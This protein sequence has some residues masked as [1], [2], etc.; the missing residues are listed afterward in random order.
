MGDAA[1]AP[2]AQTLTIDLGKVL[3]IDPR[4]QPGGAPFG[5]PPSN[6]FVASAGAHQE[7]Y[8][9]GL[10]NPF[11][12]S[13]APDGDLIVADVGETTWEEVDVGRATG[14]PAATTLA[15]AN[16]GWPICEGECPS[17]QAG[18]TDPF[19]QYGHG[20]PAATTGC[21]IIGGYVVRH[22]AL[23]GLTGRYLYGDH[24]RPDLRTLDLNVPGGDPRP[25][26]VSIPDKGGELLGFGEDG[27]GCVY[28][29]TDV[30]AYRVAESPTA[31]TACP[32]PETASPDSTPPK[33]RLGGR[34]QQLHRFLQV[35]A[36]CNEAC[37]L[38]ASGSLH[39]PGA[40]ASASA[41]LIG[42]SRSGKPGERTPLRLKLRRTAF[43]RARL[44]LKRG[45]K[46]TARVAVTATDPS[47]NR[48][49]KTLRVKLL[50]PPSRGGGK[51]GSAMLS[52]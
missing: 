51:R 21:A 1:N 9:L 14:T 49:R 32:V 12:A 17:P 11:R 8:A 28:A 41:G 4:E 36:T 2:N 20:V 16:L 6:P 44:A 35:F 42:V 30:T 26:G 25:A 52:P 39:L 10:R 3:R 50:P 13:F 38:H 33:L 27:R 7:I 23:A 40:R 19:F 18:L 47:R 15:G 22:P 45:L 37:S 43:T 48:S 46:V 24:C 5:I 34:R 29:M 31:G